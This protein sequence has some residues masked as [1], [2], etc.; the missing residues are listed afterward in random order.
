MTFIYKQDK[1]LETRCGRGIL[2]EINSIP[3]IHVE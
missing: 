2:I 1:D 3:F